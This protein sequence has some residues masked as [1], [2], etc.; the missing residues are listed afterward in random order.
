[1]AILT[2]TMKSNY[3][4]QSR[5]IILED[6]Q[7]DIGMLCPTCYM[8]NDQVPG[9]LPA[10]VNVA[11]PLKMPMDADEGEELNEITLPDG[12]MARAG[13]KL[14]RAI[15]A[16]D[17]REIERAAFPLGEYEIEVDD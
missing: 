15:Y 8:I 2:L 3:V 4:E 7:A 10:M 12:R 11:P 5:S 6:R 17:A 16:W 14:K 9:P 13:E 1:M